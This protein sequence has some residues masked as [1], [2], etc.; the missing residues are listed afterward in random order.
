MS[1]RFDWD[2]SKARQN[3]RKHGVT[4]EE[5]STVFYDEFVATLDDTQHSEDEERYISIGLSI[6]QRL[7]VVVHTERD[8][9][10]RII[11]C[12]PATPV[13]R[14]KYEEGEF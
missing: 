4:F 6:Q 10:T 7:L 8:Q 3:A 2:D 5:A 12:R 13:E 11:S 1:L 9:K 14:R